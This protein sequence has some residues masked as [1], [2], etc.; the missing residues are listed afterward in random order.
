MTTRTCLL[1]EVGGIQP[2]IFG[3]NQLA[4]NI[5]ASEIVALSTTKW[6]VD[7]LDKL[8]GVTHN[9]EWANKNNGLGPAV[10]YKDGSSFDVEIVYAGGGNTLLLFHDEETVTN[11]TKQF[12]KFVLENAPNL[13]LIATRRT[14]DWEADSFVDELSKLRQA[15][16]QRK[17]SRRIS[18][19]LLGLSVTA[20][21]VYLGLP[22][23]GYDNDPKIIGKKAA[24]K[25]KQF[26]NYQ[27]RLISAEVAAKLCYE[28]EARE[29]LHDV[30][31]QVREDI[32]FG[33]AYDFDELGEFGESSYIAVVHADGNKMGERFKKIAKT[34]T[35]PEENGAYIKAVRNLS[36][37]VRKNGTKA[38]QE[39]VDYLIASLKTVDAKKKFGGVVNIPQ[40]RSGGDLLPFRPI[41]FGGDDLT[42]VCDGR[43]GLEL[44][45]KYLDA[46]SSKPLNGES[47]FARAG[48]AVVK[49]HYPFSRAYQLAEDLAASAKKKID[50][51]KQQSDESATVMDWHFATTGMMFDIEEIREREYVSINGHSLRMRPIVFTDDSEQWRTWKT[52]RKVM[53]EFQEDSWKNRRNK[54]L[55][56]REALRQEKSAVQLFLRNYQNGT[57]SLILPDIPQNAGMKNDGWQNNECGYY[58]AIEAIDFFVDIESKP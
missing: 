46:F 30:L 37:Q 7:H 21:C 44:A 15:M 51:Y 57:K 50:D 13:N 6:V 38:L 4:Q 52:L 22:A 40:T 34:Y 19:P 5:G 43:L 3:S 45:A 47:V 28:D 2:Y 1:L 48:V 9:G 10:H 20:E 39:T 14:F 32:V 24:K 49:T 55:A 36:N 58:D 56:L 11:F 31:P 12:T 33:F 41:V 54:V 42:F 16:G 26:A 29:R 35:K 25:V 18:T 53:E 23:I 8:D 17:Q 27:P